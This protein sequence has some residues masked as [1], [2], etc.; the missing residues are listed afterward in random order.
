MT[1]ATGLRMEATSRWIDL[2]GG[3]TCRNL[4]VPLPL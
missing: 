4:Q 1:G 2:L 3:N